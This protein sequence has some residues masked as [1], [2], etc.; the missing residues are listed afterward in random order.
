MSKLTAAALAGLMT[1]GATTVATAATVFSVTS[2][3][4][5]NVFTPFSSAATGNAFYNYTGSEANPPFTLSPE[6]LHVYVHQTT[7][8]SDVSLGYIFNTNTNG[9]A[10]TGGSFNGSITGALATAMG[11][12]QD[13]GSENFGWE[14]SDPLDGTATVNGSYAFAWANNYTDGFTI[15]TTAEDAWTINLDA[16][17]M[18]GISSV[19]FYYGDVNAPSTLALANPTQSTLSISAAPVV[20]PLPA[21]LPFLAAGIGILGWMRRKRA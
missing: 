17:S 20:T 14:A 1:F 4:S 8:T 15:N 16:A 9:V 6:T 3:G 13:D 5:T 10:T 21:P 18:T 12:V 7:G 2:G 11:G 19:M